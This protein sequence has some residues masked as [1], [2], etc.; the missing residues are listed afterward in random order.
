M[1]CY[2]CGARISGEELLCPYCGAENE[3]VAKKQQQEIIDDFKQRTEELQQA[4]EKVVKKTSKFL[5]IGAV[6]VLIIF[7]VGALIGWMVSG[8]TAENALDKQKRQVAELES[9]YKNGDYEEM[10]FSLAE[11]DE[12]GATYEK[13]YRVALLYDGMLWKIESIQSEAEFIKEIDLDADSVA[14]TLSYAFEDL[15]DIKAIE[16][17]EFPYGEKEGVLYVKNTYI[18]ALKTY[19]LLTEAEIEDAM[20]Q[21]DKEESYLELANKAI[22]R[23]RSEELE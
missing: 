8:I 16:T 6:G 19:M 22:K 4:P 7:I 10:S 3:T 18:E 5:M 17:E 2:N 21:A 23:I 20:N 15:E 9:Y 14:Q 1:N 12:Y 13:Y 11:M